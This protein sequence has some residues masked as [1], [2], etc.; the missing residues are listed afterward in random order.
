[1]D[2]T[3]AQAAIYRLA[4]HGS[5]AKRA[6]NER[7]VRHCTHFVMPMPVSPPPQLHSIG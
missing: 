7:L 5:F 2:Y 1:M 3:C 4:P 6:P